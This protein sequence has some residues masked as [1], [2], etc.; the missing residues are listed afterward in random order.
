[1]YSAGDGAVLQHDVR[2]MSRPASTLGDLISVTNSHI[3]SQV[4]LPLV[5][6]TFYSVV[7]ST[8]F[9]AQLLVDN[10]KERNG[11]VFI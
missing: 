1:M 8:A 9:I 10:Q 6:N 4:L 5:E 2:Q 3:R 7:C 11:R